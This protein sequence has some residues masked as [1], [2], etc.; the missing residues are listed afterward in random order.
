MVRL[1]KFISECGYT[2]RRKAEEMILNKRV[3][4]NGVIAELGVKV[5]ELTDRVE[6]DGKLIKKE[7]EKVYIMINKPTGYLSSVSDDRGR[8]TVV[9]LLNIKERVFPVG[10]L[11]YDTEGLL[12]LTND[13]E[14]TYKVTHPKFE[15]TKTYVA[16]LNKNLIKE[17]KEKLLDGVKIE[18]YTAIASIIEEINEEKKEVLITISQGK[19]RQVR[20]MFESVGYKVLKLKRISIGNLMLGSLKRGEWKKLSQKELGRIFSEKCKKNY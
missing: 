16:T 8:K 5:D 15:I 6:I 13:G 7:D 12:I 4:V 18:D 20:K 3:K 10:R 14:F 2:S 19:N 17:D 1:Q 11:D 9:D